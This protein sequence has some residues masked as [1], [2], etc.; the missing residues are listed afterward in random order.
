[1]ATK[2]CECGHHLPDRFDFG[3]FYGDAGIIHPC[4][5]CAEKLS[6]GMLKG[7]TAKRISEV[8]IPRMR[9]RNTDMRG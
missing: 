7:K 2:C 8:K 9:K 6:G 3:M 4:P 1:M 5:E